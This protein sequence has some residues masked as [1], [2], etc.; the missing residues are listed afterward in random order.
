MNSI[1]SILTNKLHNDTVSSISDKIYIVDEVFTL[2]QESYKDVKG[3]LHFKDKD[4][5]II[6]TDIWKV[7]Y[8]NE[9]IVGVIIYK[10]KKGLK[11]VALGVTNSFRFMAKKMLGYLLKVSLSKTWM[12]VSEAAEKFILKHGGHNFLLSNKLASKL[13]GKEILEL[14]DD[15]YHYKRIINGV[16]KEKVIIGNP[17]F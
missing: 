8:Y 12:E 15:G 11:M 17:R 10:A 5:L 1:N 16:M 3:G 6:N 7:I 13:T 9:S 4:E 14:C 2:L